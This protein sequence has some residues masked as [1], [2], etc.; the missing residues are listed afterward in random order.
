MLMPAHYL[1]NK[2]TRQSQPVRKSEQSGKSEFVAK[3]NF[4]RWLMHAN[5]RLFSDTS[6]NPNEFFLEKR[7]FRAINDIVLYTFTSSHIFKIQTFASA[8]ECECVKTFLIK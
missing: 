6:V 5:R 8:L 2:M 1:L 7:K 3:Q 4:V